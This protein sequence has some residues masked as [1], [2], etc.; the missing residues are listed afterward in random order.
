MKRIGLIGYGALGKQIENLVK[1]IY[2]DADFFYFDDNTSIKNSF[3]FSEYTSSRFS[4]VVFIVALGYKHFNT[5]KTIVN[6]LINR[7]RRLLTFIHPSS[8]ID[9]SV[10]VDVGTIIY[11]NVTIDEGVKI[12]KACILYTSTTISHDCSV[13][14]C[15]YLSPSVT[16]SGYT[17]VGHSVFLGTGVCVAN[18]LIIGNNVVAGI[19]T[20]I[21]KNIGDSK[22]VIGNPMRVVSNI[23]LR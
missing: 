5:K 6:D 1:S 17:S 21:S 11:P 23:C 16:L 22:C 12:G 4:D 8:I 20:V 13:G 18:N 7:K 15:S 3:A 2:Q 19:G 9:K 14:D 10:Q